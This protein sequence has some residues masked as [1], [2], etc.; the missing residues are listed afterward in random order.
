MRRRTSGQQQVAG[1]TLTPRGRC[2]DEPSSHTEQA[3]LTACSLLHL[4]VALPDRI[5]RRRPDGLERLRSAWHVPSGEAAARLRSLGGSCPSDPCVRCTSALGT[6]ARRSPA[7]RQTMACGQCPACTRLRGTAREQDVTSWRPT[8]PPFGLGS[9]ERCSY[10]T[11]AGPPATSRTR[12]GPG[13][14]PA[15]HA[16]DS[17]CKEKRMSPQTRHHRVAH[18][19]SLAARTCSVMPS[20]KSR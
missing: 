7:R 10:L 13:E 14:A 20:A 9:L 18:A 5:A 11:L 15:R 4:L 6:Q 12:R 17:R 8:E 1:V 19:V 2:M 3:E 16:F